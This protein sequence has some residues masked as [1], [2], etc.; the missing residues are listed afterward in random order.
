[1]GDA[2]YL[3]NQTSYTAKR[4]ARGA[5]AK[6]GGSRSKRCSLPSDKLTKKEW[7]ERNGKPVSYKMREP[8]SWAEFKRMPKDLQ[9]EYIQFLVI[10]KRARSK[11]VADMFGLNVNYFSVWMNNSGW[12][13]GIFHKTGRK[14]P[15]PEWEAFIREADSE[16]SDGTFSKPMPESVPDEEIEDALHSK[17]KLEHDEDGVLHRGILN[18]TGHPMYVFNEVFKILDENAKYDFIISFSVKEG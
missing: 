3:F 8:M 5:Y 10:E 17:V 9:R 11:D 15:Y 6:K 4:L 2:E 12:G 1:M 13:K 16:A 7:K 14:T 18:Y